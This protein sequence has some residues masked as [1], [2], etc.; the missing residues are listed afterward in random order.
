MLFDSRDKASLKIPLYHQKPH[1][2]PPYLSPA[3]LAEA[4]YYIILGKEA[5]LSSYCVLLRSYLPQAGQ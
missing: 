1:A 2:L 3:S 4:H 5:F